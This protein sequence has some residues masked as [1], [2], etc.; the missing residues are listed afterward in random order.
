MFKIYL[1]VVLLIIVVI[2]AIINRGNSSDLSWLFILALVLIAI[3]IDDV[4]RTELITAAI[5]GTDDTKS[6]EDQK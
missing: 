6:T 4:V 5:K 2:G 1:G 3:G